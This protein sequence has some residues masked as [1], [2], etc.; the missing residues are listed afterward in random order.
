MVLLI[1]FLSFG[2]LP[3]FGY[4]P[5]NFIILG[6]LAQHGASHFIFL[7]KKDPLPNYRKVQGELV[8][9]KRKQCRLVLATTGCL[10]LC[11]PNYPLYNT[12]KTTH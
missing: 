4:L 6:K 11:L 8:I 2:Y 12:G 7:L 1:F 9:K 5:I 10:S 3:M